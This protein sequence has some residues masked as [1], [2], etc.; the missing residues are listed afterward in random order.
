VRKLTVLW[1]ASVV[2][3]V[4]CDASQAAE[5]FKC[6]GADGTST[7]SNFPC[8]VKP[9][10]PVEQPAAAP[11]SALGAARDVPVVSGDSAAPVSTLDRKL[12]E[13]L[14]LT[15]LSARE[16]PGVAEAAQS[17]VTRVDST[18]AATPQ[19]PRWGALGKVI[20]ADIRPDMPQLE[21]SFADA[22]HSL[23]RGLE[24]QIPEP[25]ADALLKF[26][27]GPVGVSYLQFL[28]DM[29]AIHASALRSVLGHMA[30]QTPIAQSGVSPGVA[31]MRLRLIAIASSAASLFSAQDVARSAHD[32]SP[33]AANGILPGQIA[34][35]AGSGLDD[36]AARYGTALGDFEAF[37]ASAPT[38][39]FFAAVGRPV[40]VKTAATAA[41]MS[42]FS[43]AEFAKYGSRW[44]VAYQ[45][46]LYYVT[47]G[48]RSDLAGGVPQILRATYASS[49]GGRAFDVT[50][51]MQ[52]TCGG[53]SCRIACGNQL[54][55][56][57]DFGHPKLCQISFQCGNR[58]Q[59]VTLSEGRNLTLACSP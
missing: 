2:A 41:A 51:L 58:T 10:R 11:P 3:L 8:P 49:R 40:A 24:S 16:S 27:H 36:L 53:G 19:D 57:P 48:P 23:V 4:Q 39:H 26:F 50:R 25:D 7:Y 59:N 38:K 22:D 43:D 6:V 14:Q 30:A 42:D 18:L 15:Q 1:L 29:R 9:E 46:G 52:N 12:H 55:G 20:Q 44:K 34:A 56:D 17:L 32:P 35:V 28:G 21:G 31:Q 45:H 54:A 47:T 13:L 37:N 5:V 33:Y